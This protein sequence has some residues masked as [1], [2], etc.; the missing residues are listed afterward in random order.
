ML[1]YLIKI[2]VYSYLGKIFDSDEVNMDGT[3]RI[4]QV[5]EKPQYGY[6]V[7]STQERMGPKLLRITDIQKGKVDWSTVPYCICSD[8]DFKKYELLDEDLVFARTGAT[9]GKSFLIKNPKDAIFASYLIRL[10]VKKEELIPQ[11]LYLFFQSPNYWKNILKEARGGIMPNFNASMLSNLEIPLPSK[12][13]QRKVVNKLKPIQ[14]EV[15]NQITLIEKQ[16][17]SI[18]KL[19]SSI[20]NEVFGQYE[21]PK[22]VKT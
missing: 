3:K 15:Q 16:L 10:R 12:E 18:N 22:E 4:S 14:K 19:P 5:C 7:S 6:T 1:N 8:D 9:T 2:T 11:Y 17:S 20:L 21:I 13:I